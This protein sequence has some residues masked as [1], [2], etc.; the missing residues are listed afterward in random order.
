M[1]TTIADQNAVIMTNALLPL[2]VENGLPFNDAELNMEI[3]MALLVKVAEFFASKGKTF[4]PKIDLITEDAL[5]YALGEVKKMMAMTM[6]LV[7]LGVSP[8]AIGAKP[9]NA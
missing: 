1:N 7:A 2:F 6:L 8:T 9:F 5:G 4:D 3:S